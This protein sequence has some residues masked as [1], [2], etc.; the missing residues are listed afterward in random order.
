MEIKYKID[1]NA[2]TDKMIVDMIIEHPHNEEAAAFL[3]YNRYDLMLR[4]VYNGLTKDRGWYDDCVGEL[5]IHLKGKDCSWHNLK[6]FAWQSTLGCWLR[7]VARN[8]FIEILPK[9]IDNSYNKVSIDDDNP[10]KPKIPL[11]DDGEEEYERRLRRIMFLEA[12]NKLEDED[13]KF[14]MIKRTEGYSS[15]E[16]AVLLDKKWKKHNIVK[17]NNEGEKVIATAKYVDSKAQKARNNLK[18]LMINN[19]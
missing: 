11:P 14:I 16:I 15:K 12:V 13:E 18:E 5:F 3:L 1:Y 19:K 10:E 9:L 2:L 4:K 7:R 17:F 8:K 6:S